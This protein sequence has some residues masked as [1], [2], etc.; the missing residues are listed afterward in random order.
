VVVSFGGVEGSSRMELGSA[1]DDGGDLNE[2]GL[3]GWGFRQFG[4]SDRARI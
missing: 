1:G 4:E 3:P 2:M